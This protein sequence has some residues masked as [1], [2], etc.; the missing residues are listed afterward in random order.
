MLRMAN[1]IDGDGGGAD[2][3]ALL[4]ATDSGHRLSLR[5]GTSPPLRYS[6]LG[7]N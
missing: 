5:G 4:D 3:G 7:L 2:G 6:Q 1:V